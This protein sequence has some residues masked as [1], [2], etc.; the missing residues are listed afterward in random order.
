MANKEIV[1]NDFDLFCDTMKSTVK[2]VDSAKFQ[3]S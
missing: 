3:V 2:L 1:V